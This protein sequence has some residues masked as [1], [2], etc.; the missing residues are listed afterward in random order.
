MNFHIPG[1]NINIGGKKKPD[2]KAILKE[3]Y[4]KLLRSPA[5]DQS[6]VT[7]PDMKEGAPLWYDPEQSNL[8][9]ATASGYMHEAENAVP[10][11]VKNYQLKFDVKD[12]AGKLSDRAFSSSEGFVNM[13]TAIEG[14]MSKPQYLATILA[15]EV[16]HNNDFKRNRPDIAHSI[17]T[18]RPL[19]KASNR[20]AYIEPEYDPG[21][22]VGLGGVNEYAD[23]Y[24]S[25]GDFPEHYYLSA[26]QM[27]PTKQ[28][29][30]VSAKGL[31]K[32]ILN[33]RSIARSGPLSSG[34][35]KPGI[36][37]PRGNQI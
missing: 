16:A 7:W 28:V 26:N 37:T 17:E 29:F 6:K 24:K 10:N 8:R 23:R 34:G 4:A 12:P 21:T 13:P 15:H 9:K 5:S 2:K 30:P 3:A 20:A 35:V 31:A 33:R 27:D 36:R 14:Y 22:D 32:E 18:F 1:T 19:E 25:L 11:G